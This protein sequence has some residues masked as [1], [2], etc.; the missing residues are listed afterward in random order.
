M[1]FDK[2]FFRKPVSV[3]TERE[4]SENPNLEPIKKVEKYI[5]H[6]EGISINYDPIQGARL[7]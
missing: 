1:S 5:P 7:N 3:R 4:I 6:K 2:Y